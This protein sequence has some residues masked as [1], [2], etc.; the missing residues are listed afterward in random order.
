MAVIDRSRR[1]EVIRAYV[2]LPHAT[3]ILAVLL[4]TAGFAFIARGGWPGGA[5]LAMLLVAMF[6]A[7]IAI[8]AVNELVDVEL[9]RAS[10]PSKPI[11]AGLVSVRGAT[12]MVVAGMVL[13]IV[14]SLRF[15]L[16]AFAFCAL[17]AGIGVAYSFWFKR[18]I[19]SWVLYV[20]AIPLIPIWVWTA[21]SDVPRGVLVLYPI[22]I[23]GLVAL[24][25]AQSLPD[26]EADRSVG[27]ETLAVRLGDERAR[28][29]T[30]ALVWLM[31]GAAAVLAPLALERPG[32]AWAAAGF[33]SVMV[34]VNTLLWSGNAHRGRMSL[35]PLTVGAVTAI[36]IGWGLGMAG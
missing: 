16:A 4:G 13:M 36:G 21:L 34:A 7:Q 8:G 22:A 5:D 20:L 9:D 12:T 11:P 19:W 17:G 24:Q 30:W 31:A 14:G 27:I 15:S 10:K 3:P 33:A 6:G 25:L 26:I 35:F 1:Y 2:L 29:V 32:Y 23:P 28:L 18:S